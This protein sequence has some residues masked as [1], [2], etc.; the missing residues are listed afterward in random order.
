MTILLLFSLGVIFWSFL[1]YVIHRFLGHKKIHKGLVKKEH[2]KHHVEVHYFSPMVGKFLL[3][4][5]VLIT[6]STLFYLFF[7]I[8]GISFSIGLT[9][10]Y[11]MYEITHRRFHI[12]EPILKY[13]LLMRKRH[14]YHHFKN[15]KM[16]FGVT[17][18]FWDKVFKTYQ[19]VEKVNIPKSVKVDWILNKEGDIKEKYIS[20][21]N[22]NVMIF[23]I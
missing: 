17:T 20:H 5:I 13:G 23:T 10:M 15:P 12:K 14:F 21:F 6:T 3:S 11:L 19:P 9:L 22:M 16:N 7:G 18:S 2:S 1:E 8:I 4:L